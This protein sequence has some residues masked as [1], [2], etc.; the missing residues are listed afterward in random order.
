MNIKSYFTLLLASSFVMVSCKKELEPQESSATTET[1][2]VQSPAAPVQQSTE[3]Q[4]QMQAPQTVTQNPN[5]PQQAA[6]QPVAKGMNP[7]HGQPGHRCE[8]PVGAPLNS[9]PAAGKASTPQI[10]P[11]AANAK[12]TPA[13]VNSNGTVTPAN[14]GAPAILNPGTATAAGMNPAHGQPGH[15]CDIAVGQPLP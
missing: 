7:A 11:N 6:P 4:M 12:I 10:I 14:S 9:A 15:R 13:Q 1:A 8:I 3:P 5:M 2:E